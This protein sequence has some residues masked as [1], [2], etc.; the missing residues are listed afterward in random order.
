MKNLMVII[1]LLVCV[2]VL[3][4]T[5]EAVKAG[6]IVI[7]GLSSVGREEF[8]DMFG[9]HEG[10]AIDAYK[11]RKGIKTVFLKGVFDDIGVSVGD[12]DTADVRIAVT[13]K[14]FIN[15]IRV[16]GDDRFNDKTIKSIFHLK[17]GQIM[18]Y[19]L[20]NEAL[21][22]LKQDIIKRGFAGPSISAEIVKTGKPYAVDLHL[23]VESGEPLLI[24]S[25]IITVIPPY[26]VVPWDGEKG[27]ASL[28]K[29]NIGDIYDQTKLERD[30]AR[31][32]EY[33]KKRGHFRPVVGP[34]YYRNGELEIILNPGKTLSVNIE[35]NS[36]LSV[37][38]LQ[39]ELSFFESEDFND[40]LV[41]ES[42]DRMLSLY[43]QDGYAF[44]QIAPV[45][46][47]DENHINLSFFVFEGERILVSSIKFLNAGLPS[48]R[49]KE[50]MSVKEGGIY[51]ADNLENERQS[52][53][54][55]YAALGYVDA[56][57][58]E[59]E[60]V[61]NRET[62]SAEIIVDIEEGAKTEVVSLEVAGVDDTEKGQL[63]EVI[64]IKP[65]DPYNEVDIADARLRVF[66]F[67]SARGFSNVEV[68]V[69][70]HI[71]N[72]GAS[73]IFRITNGKKKI[74][75]STVVSGNIATKYEV[76]KRELRNYEGQTYTSREL[77][78]VRQR[79]YK[80]GLFSDVDIEPVNDQIDRQDILIKVKEAD[81]GYVEF[82]FGY[83]EV[84]RFRG[85]LEVGYKNLWGMN[86]QVSGRTELSSYEKRFLLQ[87]YEPWFLDRPLPFRAYF[88]N[89]NKKVL[90]ISDRSI[91]YRLVRYTLTGGVEK[92]ISETLKGE[93]YYDFSLVRTSDVQ[94][95]VVLTKED[96]GTLAI[97]SLRPALIYDTRDNQFE[98][99]KGVMAGISMKL[100]SS[101]LLSETNF[102]KMTVFGN[103]YHKISNRNV[104]ALSLKGGVAY[105]FGK[106]EELPLVERFFLGG[107][108]TVRG[109]EQDTLGP[110]GVDNNPI[111]GN[112]FIMGN[113]EMRT[114]A[115]LGI[116]IVTFIDFGNVW[117][118]VGD[119][120][121]GDMRYTAGLGL[122][123][124]TPV[125]PLR[126]DYG[127]KLNRATGDGSKGAVHFSIG[128]AF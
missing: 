46:S 40:E 39:K 72:L 16:T 114:T 36:A 88:L 26:P 105:H 84:E 27:Y 98:P 104:L 2:L 49:L 64:G 128:H 66:E 18:R 54:E 22:A 125:G 71:E 52:L 29:L 127:Y 61:I 95:D 34:F 5:A 44:A 73:V 126:V 41:S 110:K 31:I 10:D 3:S 87:Y 107:R 83:A 69:V 111:G 43:H 6:K 112:A 15:N 74:W 80:L 82:G 92:K 85:F 21:D 7:T 96:T 59:L 99:G 32:R 37:K 122:R 13:E 119:I 20:L 51:N 93:F 67:Y 38:K 89:E 48:K 115:G 62:T 116:G 47:S 24:N 90:N 75:G 8:I 33:F 12:G 70:R 56:N 121:P 108:S 25:L 63:I 19:D 91:R 53:K 124:K 1:L 4:G 100:A 23:R 35:G 55:F 79:L 58:K 9:I 68:V 57:I 78:E 77:S 103:T 97:S 17:E 81:A 120:S 11:I 14:D 42:V 94:K 30:L 101:A 102:A 109:Y 123:Y 65:G 86:R 50:V 60:A 45:I 28:M 113:I 117:I 118:K 76:V 106:T